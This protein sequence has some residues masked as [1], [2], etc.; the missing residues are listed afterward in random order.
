MNRHDT[1][2]NFADLSEGIARTLAHGIETRVFPG[3]Q[4]MFSVVSFEPGSEGSIH[5]H[6]EEQWGVLLEGSGTR[7]QDGDDVPVGP[8]D[9]WRTPCGV[10]HGFRAGSEGA[11][12]LDVFAPPREAYRKTGSGFA[13]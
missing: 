2:F 6:P 5:S 3:E 12:V 10:E 4:A 9:F 1:F 11:K 13:A 7:I 8:G